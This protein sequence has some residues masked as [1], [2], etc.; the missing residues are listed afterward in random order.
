MD[1]SLAFAILLGVWAAPTPTNDS[2]SPQV[3]LQEAPTPRT[4]MSCDK[5]A[6]MVAA[7]AELG[8]TR[9]MDIYGD[10][11]TKG[12]KK[13][14]ITAAKDVRVNNLSGKNAPIPY[15]HAITECGGA[16]LI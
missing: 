7:V 3:E 1:L 4:V 13:F 2:G 12:E 14:V 8:I 6:A 16:K 10:R 11:L 15:I 9:F 5:Y